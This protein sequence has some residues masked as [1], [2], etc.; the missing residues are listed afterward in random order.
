MLE[1]GTE[2]QRGDG[3][4]IGSQGKTRGCRVNDLLHQGW[5]KQAQLSESQVLR[6][7]GERGARVTGQ[8]GRWEQPEDG[9]C[10]Q[11]AEKVG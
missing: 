11:R 4:G 1:E 9:S 8:W 2:P 3:S 10:P 6:N 5:A 7:D